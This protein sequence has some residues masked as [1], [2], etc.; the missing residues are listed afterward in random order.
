MRLLDHNRL[1]RILRGLFDF[2][3]RIELVGLD[4]IP[5]TGGVLGAA[6]HLSRLDGPL[7]YAILP[8]T[9]VSALAAIDYR[10]NVFFRWVLDSAGVIWL[11]RDNPDPKSLKD[12]IQ[13][14]RGGGILGI[15]PEG[16][17]SRVGSLIPAKPGVAYLA[18][19]AEVPLL[20]V[21]ITGTETALRD[22]ARL[23]RPRLQVEFGPVFTL[24][25]LDRK[26][27]DAS[28]QRNADEIMCRIAILLPERYRG[29]YADHPRLQQLLSE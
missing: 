25:P 23:R 18:T 10:K 17:R 2:F 9:D 12:A 11:D 13:F 19:K 27:R 20:P 7:I 8:R 3:C 26:D 15:A 28:L 22:L 5:P 1:R 4:N 21:A 24:P 16:T 29:V 6:N 14:L